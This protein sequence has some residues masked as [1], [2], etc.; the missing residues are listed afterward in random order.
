M[1]IE[2]LVKTVVLAVYFS[3][4]LVLIWRY[5]YLTGKQNGD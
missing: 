1:L 3:P 5:R 4:F 2:V